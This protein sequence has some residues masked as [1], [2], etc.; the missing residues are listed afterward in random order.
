MIKEKKLKNRMI[1]R[2]ILGVLAILFCV[3]LSVLMLQFVSETAKVEAFMKA[4]P[5][6]GPIIYIG[7]TMLQ[8]I[9]AL[10]PGEPVEIAG[11]YVFGTLQGTILYLIGVT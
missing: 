3:A 6:I 5:Y 4:H 8:V 1:I 9:I 2:I 7:M 11:G 10:I